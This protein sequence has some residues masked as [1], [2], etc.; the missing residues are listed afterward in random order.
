MLMTRCTTLALALGLAPIA[1]DRPQDDRST[2]PSSDG[3]DLAPAP[4][5]IAAGSKWLSEAWQGAR[6]VLMGAQTATP[7]PD[8]GDIPWCSPDNPPASAS[9]PTENAI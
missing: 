6:S 5:V 2:V 9:D 1:C 4:E 7:A 3:S 8:T